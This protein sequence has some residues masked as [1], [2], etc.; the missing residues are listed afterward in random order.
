[1]ST[2]DEKAPFWEFY[3]AGV[4]FHKLSEVMSQLDEGM[5]LQMVLEPTNKYDASAVRLEHGGK[6]LGY[7][8]GRISKD[9]TKAITHS[10]NQLECIVMRLKPDNE[11]WNQLFVR[12]WLP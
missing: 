9:V 3:V 2:K 11:P 12:V 6:M 1:M 8:P 10:N 4:K 7:V 5:K